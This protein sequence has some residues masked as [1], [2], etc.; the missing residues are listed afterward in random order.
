MR[1]PSTENKEWLL[2]R[3]R[4]L[5]DSDVV[6]VVAHGDT[7][8]R[9][10]ASFLGID[11]SA[12]G[13][14]IANTSVSGLKVSADGSVSLDFINRTP[15]LVGYEDD[16]R[17]EEFYTFMGLKKKKLRSGKKQFDLSRSM[18]HASSNHRALLAKL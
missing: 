7:I 16:R 12:I 10:L 3:A 14:G 6:V 17:N 1:L 15:H 18:S 11:A 5:P 4:E 9:T 8:W 13:H 2:Q